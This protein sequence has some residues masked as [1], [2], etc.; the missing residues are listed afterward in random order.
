MRHMY[1]CVCVLKLKQ[2]R[3]DCKTLRVHIFRPNYDKYEK[4][5][6]VTDNRLL[7]VALASIFFLLTF[8]VDQRCSSHLNGLGTGPLLVYLRK[9]DMLH[10]SVDFI[11]LFDLIIKGDC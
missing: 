1:F 4:R 3:G 6:L 7:P 10:I 11:F 2:R 9:L 5:N 8:L